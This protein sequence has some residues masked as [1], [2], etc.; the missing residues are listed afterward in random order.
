MILDVNE[1]IKDS[2]SRLFFKIVNLREYI[3]KYREQRNAFRYN[4]QG[5]ALIFRN[6]YEFTFQNPLAV[7]F[8]LFN[9]VYFL[10]PPL[11]LEI[12]G[13]LSLISTVK[14]YPLRSKFT[15]KSFWTLQ[16][17]FRFFYIFFSNSLAR[18]LFKNG[19]YFFVTFLLNLLWFFEKSAVL[20]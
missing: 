12:R 11:Y 9:F 15:K 20:N 10:F 19:L 3:Q 16:K 17:T 8:Y 14:N 5:G 1:F 6:V 2:F 18:D 13:K 7:N 4:A